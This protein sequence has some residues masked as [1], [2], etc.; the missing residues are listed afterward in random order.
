MIRG[1]EEWR[2]KKRR[3]KRKWGTGG[4]KGWRRGDRTMSE[5]EKVILAWMYKE[6]IGVLKSS[7]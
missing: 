5:R 3:S 7:D 4:D 1:A 6:K 2:Q